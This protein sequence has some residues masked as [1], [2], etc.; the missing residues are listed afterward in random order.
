MAGVP[1]AGGAQGGDSSAGSTASGASGAPGASGASGNG[2]GGMSGD[3]AGASSAGESGMMALAGAAG[4]GEEHFA[5]AFDSTAPDYVSIG[6]TATLDLTTAFTY[7]LW[8]KQSAKSVA[9]AG[10]IAK[11]YGHQHGDTIAIWFEGGSL[12]AGVNI[13]NVSGTL[14][15]VWPPA[16]VGHW[17]HVA[18]TYDDTSKA[19]SLYVDGSAVASGNGTFGT[20][21]YDTHP[22]MI[23]ADIDFDNLNYGFDGLLED[24]RI[25]SVA[26]TPAQV[27]AD[28]SAVTPLAD[29]TLLVASYAFSDGAGTTAHDSSL[30]HLDGHLGAATDVTGAP[31]W[32]V[33]SA[34]F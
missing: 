8:M 9:V 5:L 29:A 26:R 15:Y 31:T 4:N 16:A 34:P 19:E 1:E 18:W 10:L 13:T 30:N 27:L 20:P 6:D 7:E 21:V 17:H 33:T 11:P 24:V 12:H 32:T 14:T 28:M 25:F 2:N 3:L 22:L 23:G